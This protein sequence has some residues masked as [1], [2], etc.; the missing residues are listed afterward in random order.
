MHIP[1]TLLTNTGE[2]VADPINLTIR[3]SKDGGA[4]TPVECDIHYPGL[5]CYIAHIPDNELACQH[6]TLIHITADDCQT[7]LFEYVPNDLAKDIAEE[8]WNSSN[9]TLTSLNTGSSK[10]SSFVASSRPS[11]SS[12]TG[13]SGLIV[14][15]VVGSR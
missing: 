2:P 13:S 10:A 6:D 9:R 7:T 1:F 8:V 14:S 5:G 15:Q 3:L 4:F 11:A 12:S